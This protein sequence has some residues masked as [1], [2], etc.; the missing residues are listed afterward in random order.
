MI[1]KNN[2]IINT[3]HRTMKRNS[4]H[5]NTLEDLFCV[6]HALRQ[7]ENGMSPRL[8]GK[9]R[10]TTMDVLLSHGVCVAIARGAF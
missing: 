4:L 1:I 9:I 2:R 6:S 8:V 3:I 10:T 7:L 5:M